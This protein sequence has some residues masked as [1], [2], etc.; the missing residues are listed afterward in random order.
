[1]PAECESSVRSGTCG[2]LAVGRCSSCGNAFCAS[3]QASSSDTAFPDDPDERPRALPRSCSKCQISAYRRSGTRVSD[4]SET[5]VELQSRLA[6]HQRDMAA[7]RV[8]P[9]AGDEDLVDY[10]GGG[11]NQVDPAA[12]SLTRGRRIEP[13]SWPLVATALST[14]GVAETSVRRRAL[15]TARWS[16][17]TKVVEEVTHGWVLSGRVRFIERTMSPSSYRLE[18]SRLLLPD[19]DVVD[20]YGE[21][22]AAPDAADLEILYFLANHASGILGQGWPDPEVRANSS[23]TWEVGLLG[24]RSSVHGSAWL[25][26][27]N[28]APSPRTSST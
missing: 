7:L 22:V 11:P 13:A 25:N 9:S 2:V 28:R 23:D 17:R 16:G 1:M 19:G 15:S 24:A 10:L 21:L 8:L 12:W 6:N 20:Q 27:Y 4:D 3:H 26:V 5:A 18:I 14:A